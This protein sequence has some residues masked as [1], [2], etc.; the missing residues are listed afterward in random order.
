MPQ[1]VGYMQQS[2]VGPAGTTSPIGLP[3]PSMG[4]H[5]SLWGGTGGMV[6]LAEY[7]LALEA[8]ARM[9]SQSTGTGTLSGVRLP[10][11]PGP[12]QRDAAPGRQS[13]DGAPHAHWLQPRVSSK[14]VPITRLR[15]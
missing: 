6:S 5:E 3:P 9:G 8:L 7:V 12:V 10:V 4:R 2:V 15:V 14:P 11:Q 1:L 13:A